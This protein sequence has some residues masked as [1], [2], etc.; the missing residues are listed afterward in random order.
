MEQKPG[1]SLLSHGQPLLVT[2][3]IA[4]VG[5]L[6]AWALDW[7]SGTYFAIGVLATAAGGYLV[8]RQMIGESAPSRSEVVL[9]EAN[10]PAEMDAIGLAQGP[11]LVALVGHSR[12]GKTQIADWVAEHHPDWARASFG[13]YVLAEAK[14]R[15]LPEGERD[16]TDK[17]GG[18]LLSELGPKG[19]VEHVLADAELPSAKGLLLVDDVYHEP[20][21]EALQEQWGNAIAVR[22]KGR[23][24]DTAEESALD[25]AAAK[26]INDV[27]PVLEISGTDGPDSESSGRDLIAKVEA[28]LGVAG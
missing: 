18:D 21:W 25:R 3:G 6:A 27:H 9:S 15:G 19:F 7:S 20:V 2:V 16:L 12:S 28:Q 8:T 22:V 5:G 10:A 26:L 14:E 23:E 11:V 13:K 1:R 17:L 24:G 4:V